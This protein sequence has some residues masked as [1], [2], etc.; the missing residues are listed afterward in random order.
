MRAV[1]FMSTTLGRGAR[2]IAGAAM[3]IGGLVAGGAAGWVVAVVGL[4]PLAAGLAD[5]CLLAPLFHA[6]LRGRAHIG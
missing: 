4:V 3:V 1:R 5:V 2:I 6:P